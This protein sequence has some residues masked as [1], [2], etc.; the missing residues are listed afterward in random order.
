MSQ[1]LAIVVTYFNKGEAVL[2]CVRSALSQMKKGDSLIIVDDCS[3]DDFAKQAHDLA[4]E[5]EVQTSF[6]R[7]EKNLGAAGAKNAGIALAN[8]GAI[9]LLDAD[10]ELADGSLGHIRSAVEDFPDA[11]FFF[12]HY[13]IKD[14]E[15]GTSHLETCRELADNDGQLSGKALALNW[16]LLGSSIFQPGF[17]T[18]YGLFDSRYPRTDDI[19]LF[20]RAIL[21]GA[22]GVHVDKLL[23]IWNRSATGNNTGISPILKAV[24]WTR[25]HGFYWHFLSP[26]E[27][28]Q[29]LVLKIFRFIHRSLSSGKNP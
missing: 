6:I 8:V 12:G 15:T 24:S 5:S 18:K 28:F 17:F 27:Y 7:L 1:P 29:V 2:V 20:S 13:M 22:K 21:S 23:Y 14:F 19:E 4:V 26:P 25:R 3:D 16:T 11:D 10:D 9:V